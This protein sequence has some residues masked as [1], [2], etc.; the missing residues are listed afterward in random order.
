MHQLK[1]LKYVHLM[2][3]YSEKGWKAMLGFSCSISV[4]AVPELKIVSQ[5][6]RVA[7]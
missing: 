3:D 6:N 1:S 5:M 4:E 7:V 2:A